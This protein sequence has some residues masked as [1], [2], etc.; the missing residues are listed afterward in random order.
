MNGPDPGD[1]EVLGVG[2]AALPLGLDETLRPEDVVRL[3]DAAQPG[4]ATLLGAAA[5]EVG[6]A[7]SWGTED[8]PSADDALLA[9]ALGAPTLEA[10]C[11]AVL[12]LADQPLDLLTM[13]SV[14]RRPVV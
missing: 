14:L 2:A 7:G 12:L 10:A 1:D 6:V 4:P 13:A 8:D 3:P 5:P 9:D 11:E